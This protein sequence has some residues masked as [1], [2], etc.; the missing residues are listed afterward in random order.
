[1]RNNVRKENRQLSNYEQNVLLPILIKGLKSK[2]GKENAVSKN[3]IMRG[4]KN[5]GLK[6][7]GTSV[8]DLVRYI[9]I[10]D[11]IVGLMA[12]TNGY[13]VGSSNQDLVRYEQRLKRHEAALRKVRMCIKRQRELAADKQ[14]VEHSQ[15]F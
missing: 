5:H 4:L 14:L 1:M 8:T 13:Y 7:N 11:L 15:L 2:R 6:I 10:N 9:R 3:Q 12:S